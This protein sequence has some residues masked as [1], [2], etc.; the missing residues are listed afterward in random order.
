ML[1]RGVAVANLESAKASGVCV[2]SAKLIEEK[3]MPPED[4]SGTLSIVVVL[5]SHVT[6]FWMAS[7]V[8]CTSAPISVFPMTKQAFA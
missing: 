4:T 2:E 6:E 8:D 1:A 3:V 5:V 7:T